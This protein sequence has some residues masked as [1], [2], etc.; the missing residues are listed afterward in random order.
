MTHSILGYDAVVGIMVMKVMRAASALQFLLAASEDSPQ[1]NSRCLTREAVISTGFQTMM[2]TIWMWMQLTWKKHWK[3]MMDHRRMWRTEGIV[4][5]SVK[6]EQY[7]SD[8]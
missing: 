4:L 7:I 8:F 2:A 3:P 1:L 5:E 6:I